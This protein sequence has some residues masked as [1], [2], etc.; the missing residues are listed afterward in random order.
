ME[1]KF[2][3][4]FSQGISSD[5]NTLRVTPHRARA[6]LRPRQRTSIRNEQFAGQSQGRDGMLTHQS[7][8]APCE[9]MK[10]KQALALP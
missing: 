1:R 3:S 6:A 9:E 10:S 4:D 2:W 5:P 8:Q 7:R